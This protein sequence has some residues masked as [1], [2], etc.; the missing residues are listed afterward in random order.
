MFKPTILLFSVVA[1]ATASSWSC[2]SGTRGSGGTTSSSTKCGSLSLSG[3]SQ[4]CATCID[5]SCCEV[6]TQCGKDQNCSQLLTCATACPENDTA[7]G[8]KCAKQFPNG[9]TAAQAVINCA[10]ASCDAACKPASSDAGTTSGTS[11]E[12]CLTTT[13]ANEVN[14]CRASQACV[15][16]AECTDT[17]TTDACDDACIAQSQDT[18]AF[19]LL[20]CARTKC[21]CGKSASTGG[22][23]TGGQTT[24]A[25]SGCLSDPPSESA[26]QYCGDVPG[27]PYLHDCP[28]GVP[29][30]Y[31]CQAVSV[32]GFVC[33][34]R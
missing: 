24:G 3:R 13:C 6:A 17:C 7:C 19:G 34:N 18:A 22:T 9:A 20:Q 26:Q 23:G 25:P 21:S 27:K 14:A 8:E 11:C 4:T 32:S 28:S 1:L 5:T 33:C 15:A 2:S 31:S 16:A 12:N 30:G 29:A 10:T